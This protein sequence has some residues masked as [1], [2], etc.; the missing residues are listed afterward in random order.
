LLDRVIAAKGGLE[1][2]RGVK[3]IVVTQTLRN[4]SAQ[5]QNE[6]RTT[7][8]IQYPDR[9][10]IETAVPGGTN[11]QGYDGMHA[12]M[13]SQR[14]VQELPDAVSRD[15]KA[16]LR[17]DVIALLLEA[18]DGGRL[19]VR[20]LP[21]VKD[22]QGRINRALEFSAPDLNPIVLLV[23]PDTSAVRKMTF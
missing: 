10:R 3:T 17:R 9:F 12:W 21:D 20:L 8:Y 5:Q 15:A 18:K 1:K 11:V 19:A 6:I 14:G 22:P 4:P 23:D 16:T 13:K 2:L 7:N